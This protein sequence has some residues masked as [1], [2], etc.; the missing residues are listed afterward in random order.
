MQLIWCKESVR[1]PVLKRHKLH[2]FITVAAQ[3][4]ELARPKWVHVLN[5]N[6]RM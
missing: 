3:L 2:P 1:K 6:S 5:H 4:K